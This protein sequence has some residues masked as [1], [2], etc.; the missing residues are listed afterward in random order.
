[1]QQPLTVFE[2]GDPTDERQ[3]DAGQRRPHGTRAR[4]DR[5]QIERLVHLGSTIDIT[6]AHHAA[7]QVDADD[8]VT[9]ACVDAALT[10]LFRRASHEPVD[11]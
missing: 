1:M 3:V 5:E 4:T 9:E 8:L 2:G 11:R 10:V 7:R 6:S